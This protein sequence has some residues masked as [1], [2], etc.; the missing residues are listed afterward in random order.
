MPMQGELGRINPNDPNYVLEV[1]T[2]HMTA[3]SSTLSMCD[4]RTH[5]YSHFEY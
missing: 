4:G 5:A 1:R 2:T 3:A